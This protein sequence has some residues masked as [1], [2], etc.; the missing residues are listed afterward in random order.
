MYSN[1]HYKVFFD[2]LL[3]LLFLIKLWT[4]D[5]QMGDVKL[6]L[7]TVIGSL[8]SIIEDMEMSKT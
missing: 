4:F 3:L 2:F 7:T 8:L 6:I 5:L 1:T